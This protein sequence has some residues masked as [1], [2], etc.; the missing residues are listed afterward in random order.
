MKLS[1]LSQQRFAMVFLVVGTIP[2]AKSLELRRGNCIVR[3]RV[4]RDAHFLA[5]ICFLA[6]VF[7][8]C[9]LF[10]W[11][12]DTDGA[13]TTRPGTDNYAGDAREEQLIHR[14]FS[15]TAERQD[16]IAVRSQRVPTMTERSLRRA[17]T[18]QECERIAYERI[19]RSLSSAR[20]IGENNTLFRAEKSRIAYVGEG[21]AKLA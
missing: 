18:C 2:F 7:Y 9:V 6:C 12:R 10:Q 4:R 13:T 16:R 21:L 5:T 3:P 20:R 19:A 17:P 8:V 11:M 15:G 1:G 14:W